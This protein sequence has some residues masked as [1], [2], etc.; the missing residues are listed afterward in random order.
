MDEKRISHRVL[1]QGQP[2]QKINDLQ[3][4][5]LNPPPQTTESMERSDDYT[6]VNDDSLVLHLRYGQVRILLPGDIAKEN[7]ER[8]AD[9]P[10][11]LQS[12]IILAPHHGGRTS[13]TEAFLDKVNPSIA[14]ISCGPENRY[15]DPHP[16]VLK[17][18]EKKR[19]RIFRTDRDGAVLLQTDG[20]DVFDGKGKRLLP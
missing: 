14:I 6:V 10:Y 18:Y 8:L 13:S 17:R 19:T 5:I 2:D 11:N 16:D 12:D 20:T 15:K 1:Y 4:S 7:E 3:V 9:L